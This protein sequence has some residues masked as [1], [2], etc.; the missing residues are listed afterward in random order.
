MTKIR[1]VAPLL[2][3][4][5]ALTG[6]AGS[7]APGAGA[8]IATNAPA[9]SAAPVTAPPT[10]T[11]P[12]NPSSTPTPTPTSTPT[13]TAAATAPPAL[14]DLKLSSE[15]LEYVRV[16]QPVPDHD[17]A[18]AIVKWKQPFCEGADADGPGA[19]K[20]QYPTVKDGNLAFYVQAVEKTS[21]VQIIYI[22]SPKITTEH[23]LHIG[24]TLADVKKLGGV[25]ESIKNGDDFY[26]DPW[27]I[28]G[29]AGELVLWVANDDAEKAQRGIVQHI[30][31]QPEGDTPAFAFEITPCA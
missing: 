7:S 20:T 14:A 28:H 27:V 11:A 12:A 19:W 18:S 25:K 22:I 2:V 8:S 6:C 10:E 4:A 26:L 5:L 13:P 24:S 17:A 9:T 31:V 15:G 16:G 21:K 30:D 23:G 3:L 1:V 29:S